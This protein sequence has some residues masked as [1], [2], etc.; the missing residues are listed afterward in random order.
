MDVRLLHFALQPLKHVF[1]LWF[2]KT[3]GRFWVWN[4]QCRRLHTLEG[5]I[6]VVWYVY[7]KTSKFPVPLF[8]VSG[9]SS[10]WCHA[11]GQVAVK[12]SGKNHSPRGKLFQDTS[13][14]LT[15][16]AEIFVEASV[17]KAPSS[18]AKRPINLF[19]YRQADCA[20]VRL[21]K[22]RWRSS[23]LMTP[24]YREILAQTRN[25][26]ASLHRRYSKMR[27]R[28]PPA[29]STRVTH[30][31]L[32]PLLNSRSA[33]FTLSVNLMHCFPKRALPMHCFQWSAQ[34]A[35]LLGLLRTRQ[36][37]L[38]EASRPD[39]ARYS[40]HAR[41]WAKLEAPLPLQFPDP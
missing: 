19:D 6:S 16:L 28:T 38:G 30:T 23:T 11:T 36:V 1:F 27:G 10:E 12:C 7:T 41:R 8:A 39:V 35:E 34:R 40:V 18:L 24:G 15:F 22:H 37:G 5:Q 21:T 14:H 29:M 20:V 13:D 3:C 26:R 31:W 17:Q 9:S 32:R 33:A 25:L 2:A 4:L